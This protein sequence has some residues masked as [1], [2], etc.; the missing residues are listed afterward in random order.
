MR[1]GDFELAFYAD[2]DF[3]EGVED[4]FGEVAYGDACGGYE[5]VE[6]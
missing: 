1:A 4:G 2:G 5:G 3:G 6:G